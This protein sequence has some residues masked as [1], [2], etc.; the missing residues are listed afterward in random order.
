MM[1]LKIILRL[2]KVLLYNNNSNKMEL[3]ALENDIINNLTEIITEKLI[4][5][6]SRF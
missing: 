6:L 2:R 4:F 3:T 5:K 1:R